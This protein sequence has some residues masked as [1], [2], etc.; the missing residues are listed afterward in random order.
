VGHSFAAPLLA[1][2][3]IHDIPVLVTPGVPLSSA[4]GLVLL[5]HGCSHTASVWRDGPLE[6][7]FMAQLVSRGLY[8]VALTSGLGALSTLSYTL[9][10]EETEPA[11]DGCWDT[12]NIP[13]DNLDIMRAITVAVALQVRAFTQQCV[14]DLVLTTTI[15]T[16]LLCAGAVE[17]PCGAGGAAAA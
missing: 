4:T 1:P 8:A 11:W 10:L 12:R 9:A 16:L 3:L 6:R 2:A 15:L 14:N 13:R 17:A 7:A 5:F